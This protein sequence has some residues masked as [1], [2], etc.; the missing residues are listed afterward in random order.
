[1]RRAASWAAVATA[2]VG[3]AVVFV[4]LVRVRPAYDAYG[5][6]VWGR[7]AA[8]F[9]LDTSAAPSWKPLTFLFT[10]PY[11]LVFGRSALWL[12]MVSSVAAGLSAAGFAARI[13]F[14][15]GGARTAPRAGRLVGALLAAAAV[16]GIAGYWHFLLIAT[17]DPM[18]VA[19]S[20]AAVDCVLCARHRLAWLLTVL[21]CLGRPEA[22]PAALA[23]AVVLWRRTPPLRPLLVAGILA[24][25]LL[26][27][28]VPALTSPSWM[29]A[30]NVLDA[31]TSPLSGNQ[32]LA[33][34]R[35]FVTLYELPM[36]LLVVVA[37]GLAVLLRERRW[38]LIAAATASW[39][40]A[41]IA[42]AQHGWGV[43]PR[44]MLEPA[45]LLVVLGGAA[46]GRLLCG[47]LRPAWLGP[48]ASAVRWKV[49][50]RL[51]AMAIL[52]ALAVTF[53]QPVRV[54]AGLVHDGIEL[55]HTWARM[56]S[57]LHHVVATDGADRV[58]AC[59]QPVTELPFQSILAWELDRNVSDVGW[60][61]PIAVKS[62]TPVVVFEPTY[63][64][65]VIT[66][67][68]SPADEAA[69]CRRLLDTETATS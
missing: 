58:T 31:S 35:S 60:Q 36:Q 61:P 57:R 33:I 49:M 3:L 30:A 16:L 44:Y 69:S 1:M 20:L 6:L 50:A 63:A 23:L 9:K 27:F 21:V 53:A 54:R 29:S 22:S 38:L 18:I 13:A 47:E 64:G 42:L 65:W 67:L 68:H 48:L 40:L 34:L 5:W 43:A 26:W 56:I 4:V 41:D 17:A 39:L 46:V 45:A 7:Q 11:A 8:H 14:V 25:P 12:W 24:I 10:F 32:A 37:L 51:A 19:L 15:L 62:G 66:A 28:G 52:A 55:G 59:G 2:F